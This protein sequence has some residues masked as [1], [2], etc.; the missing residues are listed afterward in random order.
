[1][2]L[3]VKKLSK[4]ATLPK[5]SSE[6]AVGYDLCSAIECVVPPHGKALVPTDLSLCIPDGLYGRIAPRSGLAVKRFI[7]VGAGVVDPDYRG[8]VGILLFNHGDEPFKIEWGDRV[9]QLILEKVAILEVLETDDLDKTKRGTGGFG[10]SSISLGFY[11]F[12]WRQD[13]NRRK[14]RKRSN[15]I[16][17]PKH[18][19]ALCNN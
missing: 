11:R 3:L 6:G 18:S 17:F 5:R 9:A 1:M 2:Q 12:Y 4:A 8:N 10:L 13:R 14:K 16:S 19:R 7:D 15:Y